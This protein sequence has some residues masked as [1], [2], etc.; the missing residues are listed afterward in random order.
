MLTLLAGVLIQVAAPAWRLAPSAVAIGEG[1]DA[2]EFLRIGSV[3]L[4][5]DGS[6]LVANGEPAELGRFD[7]RGRLTVRMGRAGEGPG[8][9]RRLGWAGQIADTIFGYDHMLRRLT[10]FTPGGRLISVV[11]TGGDAGFDAGVSGRLAC[12]GAWHGRPGQGLGRP[13][14]KGPQREPD[15]AFVVSA[16]LGRVLTRIGPFPGITE[17]TIPM[18]QGGAMV[19]IAR[20][21]HTT[22]SGAADS[23]VYTMDTATPELKLWDCDGRLLRTVRVPIP[24]DRLIP[25]QVLVRLRDAAT[26]SVPAERRAPIEAMYTSANLPNTLPTVRSIVAGAGQLWVE[27]YEADPRAE[28]IWWVMDH[29]G[30]ILGTLRSPAGFRIRSVGAVQVAGVLT[31]AEGVESVRTYGVMR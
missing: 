6:L 25:K 10:R 19:G 30:R 9:F 8:E 3:Q 12:G 28:S 4:L 13:G 1:R 22:L 18:G 2:V 21:A 14:A 24:V 31:D 16:D 23:L 7:A 26:A 5:P 29:A 17:I 27:Q 11:R 20:I 15:S